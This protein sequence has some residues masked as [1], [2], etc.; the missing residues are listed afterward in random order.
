MPEKSWK[1]SPD[2]F[3]AKPKSKAQLKLAWE[4]SSPEVRI[5]KLQK[6][7]RAARREL[8]TKNLQLSDLA[9][10]VEQNRFS[11][12]MLQAD[13]NRL[14]TSNTTINNE[15]Q[16]V[17]SRLRTVESD[18]IRS[19]TD[20]MQARDEIARLRNGVPVAG[21]GYTPAL[22][23]YGSANVKTAATPG[24]VLDRGSV[25]E[26]DIEDIVIVDDGD[27]DDE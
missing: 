20:A 2:M 3:K 18:L 25:V 26:E 11:I 14:R 6:K 21:P 24:R 8:R 15:R 5:S 9:Q 12:Q 10:E 17:E 27:F 13:L 19:R 1:T 23:I 7:L 16:R 22:T 4:E